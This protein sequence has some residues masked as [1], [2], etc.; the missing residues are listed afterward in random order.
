MIA[1]EKEVAIDKVEDSPEDKESVEDEEV[2]WNR[3][4]IKIRFNNNR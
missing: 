1:E 3:F 4:D 2:I